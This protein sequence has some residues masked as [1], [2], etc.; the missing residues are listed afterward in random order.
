MGGAKIIEG[1]PDKIGNRDITKCVSVS[2]RAD[3]ASIEI[4]LSQTVKPEAV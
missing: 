1:K 2:V 4:E 3:L